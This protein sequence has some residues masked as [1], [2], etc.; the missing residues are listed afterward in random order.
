MLFFGDVLNVLAALLGL[1]EGLIALGAV[2]EGAGEDGVSFG[3][4]VIFIIGI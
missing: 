2:L 1:L 3:V 4:H